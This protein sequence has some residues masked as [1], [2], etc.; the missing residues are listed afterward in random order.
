MIFT[1][2]KLC[3]KS[4][5]TYYYCL[6]LH[7]HEKYCCWLLFRCKLLYGL[8]YTNTP[9]L[10]NEVY[11]HIFLICHFESELLDHK[12]PTICHWPLHRSSFKLQI[13]MKTYKQKSSIYI[14]TLFRGL[15]QIANNIIKFFQMIWTYTR[16]SLKLNQS[17]ASRQNYLLTS[18]YHLPFYTDPTT[19]PLWKYSYYKI[20]K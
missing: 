5:K 3:F 4:L 2:H 18:V 19:L 1:F 8:I 12:W 16:L 7:H 20:N 13:N 9:I 6:A 10:T 14:T 15:Y 17:Q 11:M